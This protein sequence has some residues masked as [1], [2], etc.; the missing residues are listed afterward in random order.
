[1]SARTS[2]SLTVSI[3]GYTSTIVPAS[4]ASFSFTFIAQSTADLVFTPAATGDAY[5]IDAVSLKK[6]TGG[7][8]TIG[9]NIRAMG[10]LNYPVLA[11]GTATA[12]SAPLK[13]T[14]GTLLTAAEA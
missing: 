9:G 1:M 7:N 5:T 3:G 6:V 14:S 2:G 13:F 12:G 8:L 4:N 11:A 10:T